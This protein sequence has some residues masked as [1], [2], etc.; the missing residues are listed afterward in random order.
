MS[1]PVTSISPARTKRA[2]SSS[3]VYCWAMEVSP[4]RLRASDGRRKKPS[5]IRGSDLSAITKSHGST[6]GV[7]PEL[8]LTGMRVV[9]EVGARG[10][11]T[12]AAG[13][14][15]YTQSA[16]SRQVSLAEQAVGAKLFE[17]G[18]RGVR[19]TQ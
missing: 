7:M 17:G 8:T 15:G 18:S 2:T 16:V 4:D 3:R 5:V 19:P 6:I 13:A 14:L 11:F 12:A 9:Y 1:S 10:S